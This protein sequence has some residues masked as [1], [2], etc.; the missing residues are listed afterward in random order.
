[1]TFPFIPFATCLLAPLRKALRGIGIFFDRRGSFYAQRVRMKTERSS[2]L[3]AGEKVER[4]NHFLLGLLL[5]LSATA[6]T[7]LA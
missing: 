2:S 6:R 4:K 3:P 1:M 5:S 7:V